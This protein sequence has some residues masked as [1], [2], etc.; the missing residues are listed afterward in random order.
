MEAKNLYNI[1][2][3]S[4]L[5]EI[6]EDTN[7][8]KGI[9]CPWIRRTDTVK[10]SILSKAS[11]RFSAILIQIP[12]TFFT[13]MEKQSKK[14]LG[15]HQRRQ[16]AKIAIRRKE[17]TRGIILPGFK[18]HDRAIIIK[19]IWYCYKDRQIDHQNILAVETE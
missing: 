6:N 7:K 5:K 2:Y 11:Y 10:M 17:I 8:Y 19:T 9:L 4:V 14:H 13:E 12:W 1:N 18:L 15:S 16:V 3:A